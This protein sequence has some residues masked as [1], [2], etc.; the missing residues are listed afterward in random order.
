MPNVSLTKNVLQD[1]VLVASA[2]QTKR[3][4]SQS[5]T[6]EKPV[7]QASTGTPLVLPEDVVTLS[8]INSTGKKSSQPVT[9]D[10][11]KALLDPNYSFSVYG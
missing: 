8:S 1:S 9:S 5:K 11:K 7:L 2:Q 4:S 6:Q 3:H 10:E